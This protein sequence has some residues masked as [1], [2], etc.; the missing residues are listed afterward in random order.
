MEPS[1][2]QLLNRYRNMS[3]EEIEQIAYYE[4]KTLTPE[5]LKILEAEIK[6]RSLTQDFQAI[7]DIQEKGLTEEE[8]NEL[9]EKVSGLP[10]PVCFRKANKLNASKIA[11]AQSVILVTTFDDPLLI[12][13]PDCIIESA[14]RATKKTLLFGW[15]GI[16]WGP[17]RTIQALSINSES[18]NINRYSQPTPEF[19]EFIKT[20][21]PAI[22]AKIDKI[23]SLEDL[24]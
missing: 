24:V 5:A 12:A 9:T 14:K 6:R 13:C 20:N 10:C 1:I 21:A 4:A 22:K 7:V 16:P 11:T 8:L 19:I 15:W 2:D 18:K 3:D 23:D 17:I